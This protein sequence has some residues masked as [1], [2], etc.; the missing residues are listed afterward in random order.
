MT[1]YRFQFWIKFRGRQD[2][3]VVAEPGDNPVTLAQGCIDLALKQFNA[4]WPAARKDEMV[5]V[6]GEPAA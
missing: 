1:R 4:R 3:F 2:V 5:C 6:G